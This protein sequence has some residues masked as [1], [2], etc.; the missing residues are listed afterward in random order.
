MTNTNNLNNSVMDLFNSF[1]FSSLS[2]QDLANINFTKE[3]AIKGKI[4]I[5]VVKDILEQYSLKDSSINTTEFTNASLNLSLMDEMASKP[6]HNQIQTDQVSRE[7]VHK[8]ILIKWANLYNETVNP[9]GIW[10]DTLIKN[11]DNKVIGYRPT[12]ET[13]TF[14][15]YVLTIFSMFR[16]RGRTLKASAILEAGER[17]L[18]I[19]MASHLNGD[20]KD[21]ISH[22][23]IQY[24]DGV[25][26]FTVV[27]EIL[28]S[29]YGGKM[30][31]K[32]PTIVN[33]DDIFEDF[34]N[35]LSYGQ[36]S[37]LEDSI[38][39]RLDSL[40][41]RIDQNILDNGFMPLDPTLKEN[42]FSTLE[43][44]FMLDNPKDLKS[45]EERLQFLTDKAKVCINPK[46][47]SK[48][49]KKADLLA[50]CRQLLNS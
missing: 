39:N 15:H 22:F 11:E 2:V 16:K 14:I 47:R 38:E 3:N 23:Y 29:V 32:V 5:D 4:A 48:R 19:F 40:E 44:Y 37:D 6:V 21:L 42:L 9:K 34:E 49:R 45:I 28:T 10:I 18:R 24:L 1:S 26:P 31:T 30:G 36:F 41:V 17:G 25:S 8:G 33:F 7:Y 27:N 35:T 46:K 50:Q 13:F 43:D 20:E 12:M